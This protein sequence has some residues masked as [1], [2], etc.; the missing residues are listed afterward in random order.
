LH[1]I[2]LEPS[3]PETAKEMKNWLERF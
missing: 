3:W 2:L 1:E